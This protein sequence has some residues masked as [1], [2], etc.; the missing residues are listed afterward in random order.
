M[1]RRLQANSRDGYGPSGAT[2]GSLRHGQS[3]RLQTPQ[4]RA[5]W[6]EDVL[7]IEILT[8]QLMPGQRIK[9]RELIERYPDLSPTPVREALSRLV[10]S[11]LVEFVAQRGVRVARASREDLFD[12]YDLRRILETEALERSLAMGDEAWQRSVTEAFDELNTVGV[13][14]PFDPRSAAWPEH[15][16]EWEEAHRRFHFSLL[17]NCGSPWL[18]RVVGILYDHSTRYRT[19]SMGNW[20]S[21]EDIVMKHE[22]LLTAAIAG[23][24]KTAVTALVD[25]LA[26][27]VDAVSDALLAQEP[28][29]LSE[30]RRP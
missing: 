4:T 29:A 8:G 17:S 27:T 15:I 23:D 9:V 20:G 7:R 21:W 2:D 12:T 16:M 14:T 22:R 24:T 1:E 26:L 6:A 19:L 25:H 10:G 3:G 30:K 11:G 13:T 28:A 18:L 5:D